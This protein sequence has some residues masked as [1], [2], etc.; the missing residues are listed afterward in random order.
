MERPDTRPERDCRIIRFI[1][2]STFSMIIN[3][4][5]AV[6]MVEMAHPLSPRSH[7]NA[8]LINVMNQAPAKVRLGPYDIQQHRFTDCFVEAQFPEAKYSRVAYAARQQAKKSV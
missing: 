8:S 6:V 3:E 5:Q 7:V 1:T 4:T 2:K